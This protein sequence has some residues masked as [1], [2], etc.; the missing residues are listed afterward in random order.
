MG[1]CFQKLKLSICREEQV[2]K[3]ATKV[4]R[5][6]RKLEFEA[7]VFETY[8]NLVAIDIPLMSEDEKL[9]HA[10]ADYN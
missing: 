7:R 2:Q 9:D 8:N 4:R 3:E 10:N 5:G 6:A 1:V